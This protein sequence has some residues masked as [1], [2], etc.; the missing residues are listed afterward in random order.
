METE[1]VER[2]MDVTGRTLQNKPYAALGK[3]GAVAL[4]VPKRLGIQAVPAQI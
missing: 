1:V 3:T 2:R 4:V